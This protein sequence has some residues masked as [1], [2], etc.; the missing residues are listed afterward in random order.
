M[1]ISKRWVTVLV[2]LCQTLIAIN[3]G[4]ALQRWDDG[5]ASSLTMVAIL[6]SVVGLVLI[7]IG[8]TMRILQEDHAGSVP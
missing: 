3:L 1:L 8:Q 5:R 7:G 6:L 4:M 2:A